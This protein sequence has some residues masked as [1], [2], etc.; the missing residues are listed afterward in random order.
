MWGALIGLAG[1]AV[2]GI[3]SIINN[4]RQQ[5]A[6][7]AEAARQQAMY[8]A[9]ANENPLSRSD[10]QHVLGQYDRDAQKQVETARNIAAIK[11]GTPEA[12]AAVQ[13]A[14]AEG[15]A[16]LMGQM[17]AGAS[18]RADY[19]NEL[20]EQAAHQ[21][22]LD[23]QER[24]AARNQTYANL[25]SNAASAAGGIMDSYSTGSSV[26]KKPAAESRQ[27]PTLQ[28]QHQFESNA[29]KIEEVAAN[30]QAQQ[31]GKQETSLP[32][33]SEPKQYSGAPFAIGEDEYVDPTTGMIY[34]KQSFMK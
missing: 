5:Q 3:A 31:Q 25:A 13:K 30:R 14:E 23:D 27:S 19:Y 33:A 32:P 6:A 22:F 29:T 34:K 18:R 21:K 24:R 15:R 8:S 9:K 20:G 1:Q 26:E 10:N 12:A 16:N 7:D 11:G 4:R 17:A 28:D 2:S